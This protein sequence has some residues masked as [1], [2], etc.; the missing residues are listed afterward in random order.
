MKMRY[1]IINNK[2]DLG[3]TLVELL[4]ALVTTVIILIA[5]ASLIVSVLRSGAKN[6]TKEILQQTK[7]DLSMGF[8]NNVRW[9]KQI[10]V[11]DG[12]TS[13]EID[14]VSY[15]LEGDKITREGEDF[16]SSNVSVTSFL[17]AQYKT[18]LGIRVEL[19]SKQEPGVKDSLY[20][21][22]SPRGKEVIQ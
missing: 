4:L 3:F 2:Q 6:S 5:T 11:K 14:G 15:K 19:E 18:S 22:L 8:S 9:A 20:L 16:T 10:S 13:V 17:V 12:G 21:V 7:N 1:Q